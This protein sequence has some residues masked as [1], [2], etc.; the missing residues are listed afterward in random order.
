MKEQQMGTFIFIV[1]LFSLII[2]LVLL[3]I[4]LIS[5]DKGLFWLKNKEK[6]RILVVR[7]YSIMW[8]ITGCIF[9]N[10]LPQGI[11]RNSLEVTFIF[12]MFISFVFLIIALIYPKIVF[13]GGKRLRLKTFLLFTAA[14]LLFI[15]CSQ[16]AKP[17]YTAEE[18]VKIEKYEKEK[19]EETKAVAKAEEKAK[20]EEEAK[21]E[22]EE[23]AK[24]EEETK[25]EAEEKAKKE[26]EAKAEEKEKEKA[27]K[28]KE[29]KTI[30]GDLEPVNISVERTGGLL[31][32]FGNVKVYIDGEQVMKVRNEQT[33][34]INLYLPSGTHEIQTKGQGDKSSVLKF[35]V[36]SGQD[37]TFNYHTEIGSIYGV[38]LEKIR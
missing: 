1:G 24:K 38:E 21:A 37:N 18:L 8:I 2:I 5:P 15:T 17:K 28:E 35:E 7:I 22:A 30:G 36:V 29:A 13:N 32:G 20:K 12:L 3:L 34:S 33:E 9:I 4:G 31:S 23:K 26:E 16:L 19:E 25:A 11:Y 27:K 14:I 10:A 6:S